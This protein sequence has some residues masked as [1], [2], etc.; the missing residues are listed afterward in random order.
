MKNNK[1]ASRKPMPI[2][3][4]DHPGHLDPTYAAGLRAIGRETN[5]QDNDRAFV[6]SRSSDDLA[7]ELGEEAVKSMTSGEDDLP[8]HR[9]ARVLEEHGG[10]FVISAGSEE[11]A[12]GFDDSNPSDA[13]R[14]PFP[15]SS[16]AR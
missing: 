13:H 6:S 5:M 12:L 9:D 11:F 7:N 2:Q 14:E 10:P 3:R 8:A 16:G 1:K 15:R 4:Q